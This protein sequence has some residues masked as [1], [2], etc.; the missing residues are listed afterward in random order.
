[1]IFIAPVKPTDNRAGIK[2]NRGHF[3]AP[4]LCGAFFRRASNCVRSQPD[5]SC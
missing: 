1:V 5:V 4:L 3:S 2:K